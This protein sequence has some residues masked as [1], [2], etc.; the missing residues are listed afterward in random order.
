MHG[1]LLALYLEAIEFG[2]KFLGSHHSYP[3]VQ[4]IFRC[5]D[6]DTSLQSACDLEAGLCSESA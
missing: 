4:Q 2:G 3:R 5:G 6:V 1:S